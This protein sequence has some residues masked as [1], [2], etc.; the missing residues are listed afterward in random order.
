[1]IKRFTTLLLG[2]VALIL[3]SA[4]GVLS[5][6]AAP[7]STIEAIPLQAT[8]VSNTNETETTTNNDE[9]RLYEINTDESQVTF[10]LDEDLRGQRTTV[11]GTTSQV[12]GQISLDLNDLSTTQVGTIQINARAL[13][14]DNNFRNRAIQNEILETGEYEF[15]TFQPTAIKGLP[16]SATF[17]EEI[18]FAIEGNLTIRDITHAITFQVTAAAS[19]E[20]RLLGTAT[21][22]ISRE[23][24][25][26]SIPQVPHVANVADEVELTIS[27]VANSQ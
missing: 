11:V 22:T 10:K 24:Y 3:L 1:M 20:T 13:A 4:C 21:A 5:E 26:L 23:Q 27:F 6:P 18:A 16:A 14:T 9:L 15:I 17:G 12:A 2:A 19:S 8:T 7:S 25:Q